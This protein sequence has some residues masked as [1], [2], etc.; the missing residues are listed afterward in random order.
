[1]GNC[2]PSLCCE[3]PVQGVEIELRTELKNDLP[4]KDCETAAF[5]KV[6]DL[7]DRKE[8][9]YKAIE[10]YKGCQELA[11]AAMSKP[12][13]E[14]EM[15]AFEGLLVAVDSIAKFYQFS[16]DMEKAFPELLKALAQGVKMPEKV[17]ELNEYQAL[18]N[19]LA[20]IF[21]FTLAFDRVRM[22]RPNLSNDFSYYRRLLPK[23]NKHPRIK[24][25]DDEASGMALFTA[26]HIPM[27]TCLAKAGAKAQEL[28]IISQ[29]KSSEGKIGY[30]LST[31]ANSCLMLLKKDNEIKGNKGFTSKKRMFIAQAM[32]GSVVIFDHVDIAG[33][34]HRRTP[35]AIKQIITMLKTKFSTELSLLNAIRYSTKNF[36]DAPENIQSLF[37]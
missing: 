25:K 5:K 6:Q 30:V 34:F 9:V 16:K 17:C 13:D 35:I 19:Q 33:S 12:S 37:D 8:K 20:L 2:P 18:T 14:T 15:A 27:T 3:K 11:R 23:F 29:G 36:R 1:M 26:E 32:T 7:L 22:L 24:V 28:L 10:E 31:M 4:V 21:N